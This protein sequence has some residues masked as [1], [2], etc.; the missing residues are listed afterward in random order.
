MKL[1]ELTAGW[2]RLREVLAEATDPDE[3]VS[4]QSAIDELG[5]SIQDKAEN[6]AVFVKELQADAEVLRGEEKALKER[7]TALENK[8]DRLTMYLMNEL[9]VAGIQRVDG[10]RARI[11][12]RRNPAHVAIRS[13][14]ALRSV[15]SAWKPY[16][17]DESNVDKTWLKQAIER[18][19]IGPELATL[20]H[21]ESL[22]IK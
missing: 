7:R 20:E 22:L 16:R 15:A 12:F 9:R 19:E 21:S 13:L 8:A 4:F 11:T 2:N 14:E 6:L 10:T 1:Y 3:I 17:Y 18:A 5:E